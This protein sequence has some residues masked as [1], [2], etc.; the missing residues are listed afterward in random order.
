[1]FATL[2]FV[3]VACLFANLVVCRGAQVVAWL[4]GAEATVVSDVNKV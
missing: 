1:M 4:K 2:E 3:M